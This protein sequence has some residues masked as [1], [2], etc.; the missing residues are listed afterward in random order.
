MILLQIYILLILIL[1]HTVH[2]YLQLLLF[3]TLVSVELDTFM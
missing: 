3:S 1:K 2:T